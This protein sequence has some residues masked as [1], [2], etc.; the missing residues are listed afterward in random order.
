MP[1]N[2]IFELPLGEP[3]A[4]EDVP[5]KVIKKRPVKKKAAK[6]KA[7][8][9]KKKAATPKSTEHN[10]TDVSE[11]S[12]DGDETLFAQ[13]IDRSAPIGP[14][15]E[16]LA[17]TMPRA[18][19]PVAKAK[20]EN[21]KARRWDKFLSK[22]TRGTLELIYEMGISGL[23]EGP[24]PLVSFRRSDLVKPRG[25]MLDQHVDAIEGGLARLGLTL[26]AEPGNS[27][28]RPGDP[29]PNDLIPLDVQI[30]RER[31][32]RSLRSTM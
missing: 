10:E 24:R 9:K 6:K 12:S 2:D 31:R 13:S 5:E 17:D 16:E 22:L 30:A 27:V 26:A 29:L 1:N 15:K 18:E 19:D 4:Q 8:K 14:D 25:R 23:E 11:L 7:K 28:L 21:P 32:R 3:A 20:R